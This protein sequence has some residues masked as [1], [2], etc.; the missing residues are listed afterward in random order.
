MLSADHAYA[1]QYEAPISV[2]FLSQQPVTS[3][4]D[5]TSL[6]DSKLVK[7]LPTYN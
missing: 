2:L 3:S 4:T 1:I 5:L 7:L 6:G